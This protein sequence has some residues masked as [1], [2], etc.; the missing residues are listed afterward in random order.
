MSVVELAERKAQ[1]RAMIF[2]A[3]AAGLVAALAASFGAQETGPLQSIWIALATASAMN[4]A[5]ILRW[6]K[7]WSP[8]ALLLEDESARDHRR[9]ATTAG[10]WT[11]I[12][13]MAL[14]LG[15][16]D[17]H[18]LALSG[19]DGARLVATAALAVGLAAFATLEMRAARG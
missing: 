14:L 9:T 15:F 11:A 13:I 7:P 4:L 6:L 16:T 19:Y 2:Y 1:V 8:L 12:G 17:D 10:F 3:L 18:R 5:P